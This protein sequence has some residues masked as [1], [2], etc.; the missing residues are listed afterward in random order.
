MP[1]YDGAGSV[2]KWFGV[3]TDIDDRRRADEVLRE[4]ERL[5]RRIRARMELLTDI[6]SDLDRV[7]TVDDG[8]RCLV[9]HLAPGFADRAAVADSPGSVRRSSCRVH[10]GG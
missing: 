9:E 10:R 4:Q 1:L 8:L 5:G 3:A 2:I 7:A 6:I